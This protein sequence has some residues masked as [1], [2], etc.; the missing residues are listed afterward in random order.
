MQAVITAGGK[1][2]PKDPL[3]Q[4]TQGGYKALLEIAGKPMIQWIIDALNAARCVDRIVI[5][6]LP[7][8]TELSSAI[9]ISMLPDAGGLV[10]NVRAGLREV[11]NTQPEAKH[12]MLLS[13]DVPGITAEML[14]WLTMRAEESDHDLS[15]LVIER[16]VMEKRY[17]LSRRTYLPIKDVEVCGGDVLM[18][19]TRLADDHNP[20]W[21]KLIASRKNPLQQAA[22]LG[23]DTLLMIVLRQIPLKNIGDVIGKR[24]GITARAVL[25]PYAEM[26]MDVDKPH[27][28]E[29]MTA[30]LSKSQQK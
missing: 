17:P 29:L 20:I 6:G 30:D 9:P 13:S 23:F 24:L 15:Y 16:S 3:Y 21:D 22:L 7:L 14:T 1:P 5:I 12:A 27:Q 28:Y 2:S 26:G 19:S 4:Y 10:A 18:L 11:K 8:F 25:C